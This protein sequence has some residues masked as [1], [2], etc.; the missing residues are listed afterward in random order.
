MKGSG[1]SE[2]VTSVLTMLR[3]WLST[4]GDK[5][6][7]KASQKKDATREDLVKY[8]QD[9][10]ATAS[11][12]GGSGYATVTSA[13]A[14]ATNYA[15]DTTFDS[16]KESDLKAYLDSYGIPVPQGAKSEELKALA[17]RQS[18]YFRYGT[19]TPSGT[20][21]AKLQSGA[22]WLLEQVKLGAANGRKEA[23]YQGEKAYDRAK[24]EGTKATHRAGG[25]AQQAHD[26]I[27]EEL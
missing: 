25:A 19:S 3:A 22:Q 2:E 21:L 8:A 14:A 1:N 12:S 9:A 24:E 13:L 10:Y 11:K 23:A 4:H 5:A 6:A 15:K 16:W 17:R 20:I 18:T 27:K 7:K 26:K